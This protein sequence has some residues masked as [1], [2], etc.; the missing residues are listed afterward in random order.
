MTSNLHAEPKFADDII[1]NFDFE[2]AKGLS[3]DEIA[4]AV[5]LLP[6]TRS[7][8]MIVTG[9]LG[10]GKTLFGTTMSW[11]Q[12][13][14]YGRT[15]IMDYLPNRLFGDYIP[16][17]D[18]LDTYTAML[19]Q[20]KSEKQKQLEPTFRKWIETYG[21]SVIRGSVIAL[22]EFWSYCKKR[23]TGTNINYFVTGLVKYSRRLDCLIL[24][25]TPSAGEIDQQEVIPYCTSIARCNWM[26][27]IPRTTHVK[28]SR[29]QVVQG[30]NVWHGVSSD[31]SILLDGGR[32]RPELGGKRYFDLYPTKLTNTNTL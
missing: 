13:R 28:I 17:S 7:G 4:D 12:K 5:K 32:H 3:E 14:Y 15:V 1:S 9:V 22:D 11:K 2:L 19:P 10:S 31:Y 26:M 16:F 24:G 27:A 29:L 23:R 6:W 21:S 20:S 25:M 30:K 18:L 8:T